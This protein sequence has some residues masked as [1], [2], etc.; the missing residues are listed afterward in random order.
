MEKIKSK[1]KVK[2]RKLENRI[3]IIFGAVFFIS[4][5][6]L[7]IFIYKVSKEAFLQ[8][9]EINLNTSAKIESKLFA[10][11]LKEKSTALEVLARDDSIYSMDKEKQFTLIQ[12][13]I[14][15][16]KNNGEEVN[17]QISSLDGYTYI[18]G[19]DISFDLS[20]AT[21]FLETVSKKKTVFASPLLSKGNGKLITIIT[22]PIYKDGDYNNEIVGV[23]GATY[24]S[25]YFNNLIAD[26]NR[27]NDKDF[28]FMIDKT[29]KKVVH[30]DVELVK[31]MD[32]DLEK[33]DKGLEELKIIEQKMIKGKSGN[34][35]IDLYG[36][37]YI[38]NYMPVDGTDWFLAVV[39]SKN[40]VLEPLKDMQK[41]YTMMAIIFFVIVIIISIFIGRRI[42]NPII[43]IYKAFT[44]DENGRV[45]LSKLDIKTGDEIETLSNI[46]N[47]FSEQVENV[48]HHIN[49]STQNLF[50]SSTDLSTNVNNLS[51]L[52]EDV[53]LA[54]GNIAEGATSQAQDT[55]KA[56]QSIEQNSKSLNEMIDVLNELQNAIININDKKDE[57]RNAILDLEKLTNETKTESNYVNKIILETN[58][59]AESISKASEMIQSIAD[60][61]NLLALNAAIEAARA[62]E[63][64]KGFAV[65]AEEIRKLAEDSTKFTEEIRVVIDDLKRKSQTAVDRMSAVGKIV[66]K[67]DNQAIITQDKFTDIEKAVEMSKQI[68]YKL[69]E[70]SKAIDEKNVEII[71]VIQNLSAIAEEN[72]ATTEEASASVDTQT[73]SINNISH[74]SEKLA[75]IASELQKDVS[76]FKM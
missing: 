55:T 34:E 45:S 19:T 28:K 70:N 13:Q 4:L 9:V 21:N 63:S 74:A 67:Q 35:S 24:P 66:E 50:E 20:K 68:L 7:L 1:Q 58:E 30:T 42:S 41:K 31:K 40:E 49:D 76:R 3:A 17:Y 14:A 56:A 53:S 11:S 75:E 23:L 65:V 12:K 73:Q 32:N 39:K 51:N 25:E 64:G 18:P 43:K 48:V 33:T 38:I 57:G 46:L 54:V 15:G 61:T 52:A 72:A 37:E 2:N 8:D 22:T 27:K 47:D 26:K 44:K 71:R 29:G 59:S 69:N 60:Q 16:F 36:E 6:I 5:A 62:G 10:T